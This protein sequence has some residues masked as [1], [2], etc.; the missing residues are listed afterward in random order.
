MIIT[1][2]T[3]DWKK[4]LRENLPEKSI[5]TFLRSEILAQMKSD[6]VQ[7]AEDTLIITVLRKSAKSLRDSIEVARTSGRVDLLD[8]YTAELAVVERYLPVELSD[9]ELKD[10][11][12]RT[13]TD[14]DCSDF[15]TAM[16]KTRKALS[17]KAGMGRIVPILREIFK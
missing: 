10:F 15:E 14:A 12:F 4:S 9:E 5:I 8:Q 3:T 7:S 16:S 1:Q 17:A 2:I 6:G 13:V 11:V